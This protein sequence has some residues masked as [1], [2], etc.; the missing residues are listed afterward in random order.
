VPPDLARPVD[1]DDLVV[2]INRM[3]TLAHARVAAPRVRRGSSVPN[4]V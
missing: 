2:A 1:D 3:R 4:K